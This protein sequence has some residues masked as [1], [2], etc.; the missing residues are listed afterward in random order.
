MVCMIGSHINMEKINQRSPLRNAFY[1]EFNYMYLNIS[2]S[3][4]F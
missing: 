2:D 4:C 1:K 3:I